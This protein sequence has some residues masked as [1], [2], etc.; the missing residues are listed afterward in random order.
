MSEGEQAEGGAGR[1]TLIADLTAPDSRTVEFGVRA[2]SGGAWREPAHSGIRDGRR[3]IVLTTVDEPLD[4]VVRLPDGARPDDA[5]RYGSIGEL[6]IEIGAGEDVY[7]CPQVNLS[8]LRSATLAQ[9]V[10]ADAVLR[11]VV[12]ASART[13]DHPAA[14]P[15][16]VEMDG[17]AGAAMTITRRT[18]GHRTHLPVERTRA[19]RM[20]VDRSASMLPHVRSG[21]VADLLEV[22]RGMNAVIGSGGLEV[23]VVSVPGE[24]AHREVFTSGAADAAALVH[25][26]FERVDTGFRLA[27]LAGRTGRAAAAIYVITDAVPP[28]LDNFLAEVAPAGD[29]VWHLLLLDQADGPPGGARSGRLAM[30]TVDG[31]LRPATAT[32]SESPALAEL[33]TWA[34]AW[35]SSAN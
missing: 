6:R 27:S 20:V 17:I 11:V 7:V 25:Q 13:P 14:E 15:T 8:G 34:V 4:V 5:F 3:E 28:D 31:A 22:G 33:I 16:T 30:A 32:G 19:I 21:V 24:P 9:L 18:I 23:E 2:T 29:I 26:L 10:P 35:A 12:P 1:V